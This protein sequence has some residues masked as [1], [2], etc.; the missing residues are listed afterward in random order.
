MSG[1]VDLSPELLEWLAQ[2]HDPLT[3]VHCQLERQR[4]EKEARERG[5]T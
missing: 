4:L 3:C 1:Q 2:Q 5:A